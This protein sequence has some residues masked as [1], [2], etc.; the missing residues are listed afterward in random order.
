MD[1]SPLKNHLPRR[2]FTTIEA[3]LSVVVVA[4]IALSAVQMAGTSAVL[5][6]VQKDQARGTALARQLMAE[7]MQQ[8]YIDPGTSP[9]F[10]PESAET[11]ATYDDVDDYNGYTE[12]PPQNNDASLVNGFTGWTR[13]TVVEWVSSSSPGG[14]ASAS[15]TGLKRITITVTNP[16]GKTFKLIGWRSQYGQVDKLAPTTQRVTYPSWVNATLQGGSDTTT[17]VSAGIGPANPGP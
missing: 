1:L 14:T 8:H 12:S 2:G 5:T 9:V 17:S 7:I 11:R 10:G 16:S 15:E 4:I 13:S 6:T 3:A